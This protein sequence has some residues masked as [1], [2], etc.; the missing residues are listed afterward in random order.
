M[1]ADSKE[2]LTIVRTRE[3]SLLFAQI[4]QN[5]G[6]VAWQNVLR[7]RP[8]NQ[9]RRVFD[10]DSY[11]RAA[12]LLSRMRSKKS[13]E[14][15]GTLAILDRKHVGYAWASED[16]GNFSFGVQ[17]AKRAKGEQPVV[18][19]AQINVR[20][21]QQGQGIGTVLLKET[22]SPFQSDRRVT[23]DVFDENSYG[24]QWFR[25][26]GFE[27]RPDHAVDP[28]QSPEG[29]DKHFG[30]DAAHALQWHFEAS[31]VAEVIHR[32]DAESEMAKL[33]AYRV[34]EQAL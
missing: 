3:P 4:A 25:H 5:I 19:N 7:S 33:R 16:V 10:P 24:L 28:N 31:S 13:G 2:R 15:V 1:I 23:A 21:E 14:F 8:D 9:V 20:P 18:W 11:G 12:K 34:I 29:P 17:L 6:F 26:L 22:I 27:P 32:I 30:A